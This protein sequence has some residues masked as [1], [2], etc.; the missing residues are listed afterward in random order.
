VQL[1][2]KACELP[3][4]RIQR[5]PQSSQYLSSTRVVIFSGWVLSGAQNTKA[6]H[7]T[8]RR[9]FAGDLDAGLA[10]V[11]TTCWE[12]LV[13]AGLKARSLFVSSL[14]GLWR[15]L[16]RD[17]ALKG[18]AQTNFA[19]TRLTAAAEAADSLASVRHD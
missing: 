10:C 3:K 8:T 11:A 18:W 9:W 4:R 16:A 2:Q 6:L 7:R 12:Y 5:A 13:L 19:A 15:F 1:G 17:P 14:T